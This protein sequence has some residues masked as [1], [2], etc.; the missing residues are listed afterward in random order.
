MRR[1]LLILSFRRRFIWRVLP[2]AL[3][4]ALVFT[5]LVGYVGMP[6]SLVLVVAFA[7][8]AV[9]ALLIWSTAG[10]RR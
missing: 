5:V 10:R 1:R 7:A 8:I 4:W 3:L 6:I 9:Q 2:G